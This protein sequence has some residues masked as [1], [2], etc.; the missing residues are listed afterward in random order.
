M[1]LWVDWISLILLAL[2]EGPVI[3]RERMYSFSTDEPA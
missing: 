1:T 3:Y 2:A